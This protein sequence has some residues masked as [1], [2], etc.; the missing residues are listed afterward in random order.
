[1]SC[2]PAE[3]SAIIPERLLAACPLPEKMLSSRRCCDNLCINGLVSPGPPRESSCR[4]FLVVL[5]CP[6]HVREALSRV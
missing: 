6:A 2:D 3:A 4:L 5:F 1:V